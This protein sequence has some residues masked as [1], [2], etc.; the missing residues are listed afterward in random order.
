MDAWFHCYFTLFGHT[1]QNST[2]LGLNARSNSIE[3]TY[4]REHVLIHANL[5]PPLWCI[6]LTS[7]SS[8]SFYLGKHKKITFARPS[9]LVLNNVTFSM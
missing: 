2:E 4:K 8:V 1:Y 3:R 9:P 7:V 5:K 6:L